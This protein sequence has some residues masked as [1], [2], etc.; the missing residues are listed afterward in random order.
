MELSLAVL[1]FCELNPCGLQYSSSVF[2]AGNTYE[3]LL[4]LL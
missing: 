3:V 1:S 2:T 4:M